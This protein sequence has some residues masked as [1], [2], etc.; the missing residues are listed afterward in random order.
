MF[1]SDISNAF[2][3]KMVLTKTYTN[4]FPGNL[5]MHPSSYFLAKNAAYFNK[6]MKECEITVG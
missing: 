4:T 6:P 3:S 5:H 1:D 2:F